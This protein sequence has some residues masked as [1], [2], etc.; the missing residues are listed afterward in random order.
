ML[1]DWMACCRRP[2]DAVS[3]LR[4][5]GIPAT[6]DTALDIYDHPIHLPHSTSSF[7]LIG[8]TVLYHHLSLPHNTIFTEFTVQSH[9][10]PH[11]NLLHACTCI[12]QTPVIA[13]TPL[14]LTFPLTKRIF[15][16]LPARQ[17]MRVVSPM[18]DAQVQWT[19]Y[20]YARA[21]NSSADFCCRPEE[22]GHC[23]GRIV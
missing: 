19:Q 23:V 13:H 16:L 12:H 21:E 4:R 9:P 2:W 5:P 14:S 7:L 20:G 10:L 15:V 6:L 1:G 3:F 11:L 8:M 18:H 22:G 17:T